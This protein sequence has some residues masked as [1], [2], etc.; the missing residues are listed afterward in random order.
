MITS[1]GSMFS[2]ENRQQLEASFKDFAS[3][4]ENKPLL[5]EHQ[6]EEVTA[7]LLLQEQAQQAALQQQVLQ[8]DQHD[9]KLLAPVLRSP[10]LRQLL[11]SL[12][13]DAAGPNSGITPANMLHSSSSSNTSS[14]NGLQA[15]LSNPR[16]MQLL[17]KAAWALKHGQ[18][19]EQ[20]LAQ[21]LQQQLKVMR[22]D[23]PGGTELAAGPHQAVLPSHMLVEALNEHLAERHAGNRAYKQQQYSKAHHHYMRALA[24]VNFVVGSNLDDQAEVD[25]NKAIVLM[26]LA[27]LH[28]ATQVGDRCS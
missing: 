18:L 8:L 14:A 7:A 1:G 17:R 28:M 16:V 10:V 26:N 3:R 6:K 11:V 20:Q 4:P 21:V 19:N 2:L 5:E 24:V 23:Q 13:N 25:H 22:E 9:I 15:W 27:A 12:S